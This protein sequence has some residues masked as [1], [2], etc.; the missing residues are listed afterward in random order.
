MNYSNWKVDPKPEEDLLIDKYYMVCADISKCYPSIYTH[1]IKKLDKWWINEIEI[2][3]S[4]DDI[5]S[6]YDQDNV[7]GGQAIV[8]I[9]LV[10]VNDLATFVLS[11]TEQN[12]SI[13]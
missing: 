7:V 4:A 11:L 13:T 6:D 3:T 12:T 2:P 8:L 5:P 9:C 1:S 10:R